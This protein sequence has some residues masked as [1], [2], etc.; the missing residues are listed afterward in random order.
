MDRK[1]VLRRSRSLHIERDGDELKER[2]QPQQVLR[3]IATFVRAP[4]VSQP[5]VIQIEDMNKMLELDQNLIGRKSRGTKA[6]RW[7][8]YPDD[9][10]KSGWEL[11][12]TL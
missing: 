12:M 5:V 4:T 7:M 2:E 9:Q 8:M 10:L 1:S 6:R 3:S 11:V